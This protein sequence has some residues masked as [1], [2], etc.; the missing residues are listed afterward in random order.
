MCQFHTV[1]QTAL[2]PHKCATSFASCNVRT[3]ATAFADART[4]S[5]LYIYI[6]ILLSPSN[7]NIW[8]TKKIISIGKKI[9]V[10][11]NQD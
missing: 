4:F 3:F 10:L 9:Y 6:Y 5:L 1:P 8:I 2:V 7:Y 11:V